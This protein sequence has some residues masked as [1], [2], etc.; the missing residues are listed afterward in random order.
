MF[1]AAGKNPRLD[2]RGVTRYAR[3]AFDVDTLAE[4]FRQSCARLVLADGANH[5]HLGA[6]R[7]DVVGRVARAAGDHLGRVVLEDEHRRFARHASHLT[8]DE[9]IREEIAND[10]EFGAAETANDFDKH[11][12]CGHARASGNPD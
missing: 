2:R 9:F 11:G 8:V 4:H 12:R 10:R 3:D 5:A 6:E 7:G 1:A